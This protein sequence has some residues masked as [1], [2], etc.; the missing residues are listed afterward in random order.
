MKASTFATKIR[1]LK[2]DRNPLASKGLPE[3]FIEELRSSY[4]VLPKTER[5]DYSSEITELVNNFTMKG[6]ELFGITFKGQTARHN[7]RLA[8]A[9][10]ELDELAIDELDSRVKLFSFETG[11]PIFECAANG[12]AFLDALYEMAKIAANRITKEEFTDPCSDALQL[13]KLSRLPG[14]T[15]FYR[16]VLGCEEDALSERVPAAGS[17]NA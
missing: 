15:G 10:M 6:F 14:S 13:V 1:A 9:N 3:T 12:E 16:W 4:D 5:Q 8:F 7:G 17:W 2:P 11:A